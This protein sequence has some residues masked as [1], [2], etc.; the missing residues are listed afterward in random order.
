VLASYGYGKIDETEL[1]SAP[2]IRRFA[3]LAGAVGVDT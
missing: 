1:G 2:R 3:D